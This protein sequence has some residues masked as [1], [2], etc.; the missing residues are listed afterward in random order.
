[1]PV[2]LAWTG[3]RIFMTL[4]NGGSFHYVPPSPL[5]VLVFICGEV[6][7]RGFLFRGIKDSRGPVVALLLSSALFA[8]CMYYR[9]P[10]QKQLY[11]FGTGLILGGARWQGRSTL[12]PIII[13]IA[14]FIFL[15]TYSALP[16]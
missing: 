1:M 12:L 11:T 4:N 3:F 14:G 6:V 9:Y 8:F 7:Y 2:C 13:A 10:F 16:H 15:L 5:S